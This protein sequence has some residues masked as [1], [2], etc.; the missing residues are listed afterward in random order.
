MCNG[1]FHGSEAHRTLAF[2]EKG[3]IVRNGD[4]EDVGKPKIKK[5]LKKQW[6]YVSGNVPLHWF[7]NEN[8]TG[9]VE[10]RSDSP[11]SGKYYMRITGQYAF[12]EQEMKIPEDKPTHYAV[13]M[14]A[15]GKGT[16][17]IRLR[18]NGKYS[19]G[20][21]QK[22]DSE[23]WIPVHGV[24]DLVSDAKRIVFT[25]RITGTLDLDDIRV[26]AEAP[27]DMPDAAK[28]SEP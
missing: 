14:R 17:L 15:R 22:I 1:V 8:N 13:S 21:L 4:F 19:K 28:H 24:I 27:E 3:A 12:V 11:A 18:K 26:T 20:I 25:C 2:G 10:M 23:K 5:H 7:F 9:K 6:G 16:L